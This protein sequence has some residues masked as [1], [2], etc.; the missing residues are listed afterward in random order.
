MILV[1][2]IAISLSLDALSLAMIYGLVIKSN[3]DRLLLSI[4]VGVFHF[5][6]PLIGFLFGKII[7]NFIILNSNILTFV[8][9]IYIGI[10]MII[11][12]DKNISD[13][14][15]IYNM[16]LFGFTVSLDSFSVGINY[17]MIINNYFLSSFI[18]LFVSFLFTYAGLIISNKISNFYGNILKKIGGFTLIMIAFTYI[19]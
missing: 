1:F 7:F 19:L 5:F 2:L 11:E 13:K 8:I 3:Y 6:M 18:F 14:K 12:D 4:I 9:F 16:L 17:N 15:N 10:E